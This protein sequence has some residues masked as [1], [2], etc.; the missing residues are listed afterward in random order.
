[1][2]SS[3]EIGE[4]A[5]ALSKAQG[6]MK[7]AKKTESNPFFKSKYA[8]LAEVWDTIR[9][10]LAKNNLAVTQT[11]DFEVGVASVVIVHTI[12][13]HKSGQWIEGIIKMPLVKSDPQGIGSAMTYARRYGLSAIVGVASE[14]D[15]DGEAAMGRKDNTAQQK[16]PAQSPA[17]SPAQPPAPK[18][19]PLVP[20]ITSIY[21]MCTSE[22]GIGL[23]EA[24]FLPY[25]SKLLNKKITASLSKECSAEELRTLH[26]TIKEIISNQNSANA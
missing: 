5:D 3:P 12:L 18:P 14:E 20:L 6:M 11:T 26:D 23:K 17:Q 21:N 4:L 16:A 15:D 1:M 7:S 10:P 19:N 22:E 9:E 2:F 24:E 13:V 25:I 8:D